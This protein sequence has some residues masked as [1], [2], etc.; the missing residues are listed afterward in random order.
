MNYALSRLE[1]TKKQTNIQVNFI[2]VINNTKKD[3]TFIL[4][5]DDI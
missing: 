3:K 4:R 1:Y 5:L 2:F